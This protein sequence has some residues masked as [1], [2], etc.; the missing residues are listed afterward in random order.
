[1]ETAHIQLDVTLAIAAL[2]PFR[3]IGDALDQLVINILGAQAIVLYVLAACAC[4]FLT[5][6][7]CADAR[8]DVLDRNEM[9]ALCV[10]AKDGVGGVDL[11]LLDLGLGY[12][13]F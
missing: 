12:D 7:A 5:G 6:C 2:L 9:A 3:A 13:R 11:A 1:M 4:L 10:G 8:T